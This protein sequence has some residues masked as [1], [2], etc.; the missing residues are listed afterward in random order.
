MSIAIIKIIAF[1]I[2][3]PKSSVYSYVKRYERLKHKNKHSSLIMVKMFDFK[4]SNGLTNATHIRTVNDVT[5]DKTSYI[6]P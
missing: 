1:E 5:M 4:L 6:L 2:R 3:K